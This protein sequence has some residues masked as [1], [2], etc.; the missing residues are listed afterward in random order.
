M[1]QSSTVLN[2]ELLEAPIETESGDKQPEKNKKKKLTKRK[3]GEYIFAYGML[4]LPII[5][6]CIFY[7]WINSNSIIMAF[8][9]FDGYSDNGGELFI[10]S[11]YNFQRF[12]DEWSNPS[13]MVVSALKNTLKYFAAGVC[14][15]PVSFIVAY[16]LYKKV[17]G[18][19]FIRVVF[20]IH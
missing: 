13:S 1:E 19:K 8:Q 7:I 9:E 16:F 4:I 20:Y 6:F 15:I 3:L 5:Q 2:E 17:W 10:W 14:M 11:L 12:F 18:Y